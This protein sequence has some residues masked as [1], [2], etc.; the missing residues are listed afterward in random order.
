MTLRP[1]HPSWAWRGSNARPRALALF[2]LAGASACIIPDSRIRVVGDFTN[3]GAVRIVQPTFITEEADLACADIDDVGGLAA[4]PGVPP[5]LPTGL[6]SGSFCTCA[7]G[8]RD[9]RAALRFEIYVEDPDVDEE[10][11]PSDD[12]LGVFLLDVP[13]GV[14]E[15]PTP[16]VAYGNY[17]PPDQPAALFT[18]GEFPVIERPNPNLRSWTIGEDVVDLCNDNQGQPIAGLAAAPSP[19]EDPPVQTGLHEL[20]LV[21]TDRPWYRPPLL[22]E[23][24][25]PM[26]DEEGEILRGDPMFGVPDLAAGATYDTRSFVFRC[27]SPVAPPPGDCSC[28][29]PEEP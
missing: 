29:A 24:D 7:A 20:R 25:E 5:G 6:L 12:V 21:V 3:E 17:L 2:A 15:D 13:F 1:R 14:I 19:D 9:G 27:Y 22:D 8:E 23:D 4:C 10:G 16:Y 26:R 18:A 11:R 28:Q